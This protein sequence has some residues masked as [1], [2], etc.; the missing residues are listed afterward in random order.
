MADPLVSAIAAKSYHLIFN[1]I[2]GPGEPGAKLMEIQSALESLPN[3]TTHLTK[4]EVSAQDLAQQAV[5]AGADV[6]IAAGGDGT[7]SGVAKALVDTDVALGIIPAGTANA[8]AAALQIPESYR[9]ACEIIQAGHSQRL[10]TARCNGEMMLLVAC[11]G[12]ESNLLNRM[13][14]EEKS[15][16]GKLAIVVNSFQ[17]LERI[18][19]FEAQVHTDQEQWREMTTAV[20]IANTATASMVLAQGPPQNTA[21]DG[22]LSITMVTPDHKWDMLMSAAD[23]FLSAVQQRSAQ[24]DTVHW[25]ESRRVEVTTEPPQ[26]VF[27]DGEPAG[28]TPLTVECRPRSLTVLTPLS[29]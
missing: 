26:A 19:Q 28:K 17:E 13:D 27:V 1:P 2:S 25:Y 15:R 24:S 22:T 9:D 7:V 23:L 4:P 11:I 16:L 5:A 20:T 14:R 21:D 29:R 6:V 18:E 12:F 8:F 10:D 3:F